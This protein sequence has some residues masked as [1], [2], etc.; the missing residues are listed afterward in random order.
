MS[1]MRW[2]AVGKSLE[3]IEDRPSPYKMT[4][5]N[6]VPR[7][8]PKAGAERSLSVRLFRPLRG[9]SVRQ[10]GPAVWQSVKAWMFEPWKPVARRIATIFR[11]RGW[12][13]PFAQRRNTQV[14]Q[15]ELLLQ[16]VRVV[17]NDLSDMDLDLPAKR[18]EFAETAA[19]SS[20]AWGRLTSR[21]FGSGQGVR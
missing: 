19:S 3:S 17:R 12:K 8:V 20:R 5:Q 7:F 1:L 18:S 4:Q 14:V 11:P 13:N 10:H 21:I 9:L 16:S 6:L 15:T 2:L